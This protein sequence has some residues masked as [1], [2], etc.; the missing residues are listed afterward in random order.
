MLWAWLAG[1][2]AGGLILLLV[3]VRL[4]VAYRR[5]DHNDSLWL[6]FSLP[7]DW[8]LWEVEN[9][10]IRNWLPEWPPFHLETL[11]QAGG[12]GTLAG[13][14]LEVRHPGNEL[15]ALG[16]ALGFI[17]RGRLAQWLG[18]LRRLNLIWRR[19][20]ARTTCQRLRVYLTVGT[21]EPATTALVYG[22][23]WSLLACL[24]Q[25]LRRR[26]CLDFSKP[27]LQ[28]TPRF[29]APALMGDFN[30]ILTFRLGHIISVSLRSLWLLLGT[31][32]QARGAKENAR[33]SHRSPDEDGYGKHQGYG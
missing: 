15:G 16:R 31:I 14:E 1:L 20:F 4:E 21:G 26:S 29:A 13:G 3:P 30:C 5:L 32:R 8:G 28:V 27:E 11:L 10:S 17:A 25:N 24:Y 2:L 19:F 6:E 9:P 18:F 33:T 7:G 22:S 23:A 12:E